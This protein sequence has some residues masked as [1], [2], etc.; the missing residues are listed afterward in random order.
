MKKQLQTSFAA[1]LALAASTQMA[2]ANSVSDSQ[3]QEAPRALWASI[4]NNSKA[5]YGD[6]KKYN[7]KV[8]VNWRFL[9]TDDKNTAFDLYRTVNGVESKVNTEPIKGVT[10]Y[11]DTGA[12][13]KNDNT[14]RLTYAGKNETL[15]TYTITKTRV[16][17]GLP[18]TSIPLKSTEDVHDRF[19]YL[20][21]DVSV[22]DVD[23]DGEYEIIV[24]RCL[25]Y[26]S[27]D[28][29]KLPDDDTTVQHMYTLECYKLD[30]TFLWRL[31]S[32][33][34][35]MWGNSW[36]F[37]VD[38]FNG[39]GKA[40]VAVRTS[41]GTVFGDETEIGDTD[42][43]GI[44]YY[45][46][47]ISGKIWAE[48]EFI[49]VL[50]GATGK[51]L[52]RAPYIYRD[53][54]ESWGDI[55]W[56]RAT[57]YRVASANVNGETPSVIIARGVYARSVLEAWDLSKDNKLTKRWRFDTDNDGYHDWES[58]GFHSL[59]VGDVDEDG[60]DEIVY[61][62]MTVDHDGSGLNNSRL[63]HGD[64]LHLGKFCPDREGLQIWSCFETGK[65][66]AALRDA[67]TGETI[68]A[69]IADKEG[70]CGRAMV[71]DID[72]KSPGCEMWRAGGN[73]YSSTGEDLGYK[74][75]SCNMG[76]WFSGSLN[77]QLLNGTTIDATKGTEGFPSGRVFTL[78]RYDVADINDSKKNPCWYGDLF[79]DWREEVILPTTSAI[80][81]QE[82]RIFSTWYPTQYTYPWLMTD[83]VYKMSAINQ[84]IGYNQP[85]HT[86]YYLGS[87]SPGVYP[88]TTG[89]KEIKTENSS[90]SGKINNNKWYN[91]MGIEITTPKRGVYIHNGKKIVLK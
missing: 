57:S 56:K 73:A 51:E 61:G 77:R 80:E 12:D 19:K 63:G 32:G 18:Y 64:A 44:T 58:Q 55:Y 38:D 22:G 49:S 53:T 39:D 7:K 16:S 5:N 54:S 78:Y 74:P 13:L 70:D 76:I 1:F 84:N 15:G 10:N 87:D 81:Q 20:A 36:S 29:T 27:G 4:N 60:F 2:Q 41:E 30:G 89:I 35:I 62:S 52:A 9:P 68:W 79:G 48:P 46:T 42:G 43:D 8:L 83:H 24:K 71:A 40:E 91:M 69:D 65:T 25:E 34:N 75:S 37:A 85:T 67:K 26:T 90:N 50:E 31:K 17:T 33:P 11:T 28:G 59:S 14:Y 82:L 86:G 3:S 6:Y 45:R 21:N 23:G 66:N 47:S 72:P 88:T